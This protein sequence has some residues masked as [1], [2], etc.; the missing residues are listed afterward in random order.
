MG[1]VRTSSPKLPVV[2]AVMTVGAQDLRT[3]GAS[4]PGAVDVQHVR[5]QARLWVRTAANLHD[6]VLRGRSRAELGEHIK[7]IRAGNEPPRQIAK[8]LR[9]CLSGARPMA[10]QATLVLVHRR[11]ND[12]VPIRRANSVNS[13]LR[14][15]DLRRIRKAQSHLSG[16]VWIVTVRTGGVPVVIQQFAFRRRM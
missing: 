5:P 2:I 11:R 8:V 10:S 3:H 9:I 6:W 7:R 4:W 14:H 13:A 1:T 12:A 15:T 16:S